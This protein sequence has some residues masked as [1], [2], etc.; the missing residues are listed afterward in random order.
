M[1]S[2]LKI[3]PSQQNILLLQQQ[4][5]LAYEMIKLDARTSIVS[6]LCRIKKRSVLQL[7]SEVH[8][9][10]ESTLPKKGLLPF[11]PFWLTKSP[12]NCL[13]A[14]IFYQIYKHI[15]DNSPLDRSHVL[16]PARIF[17][18]SFKVYERTANSDVLNINRAWSIGQQIKNSDIHT[19]FC[20]R[21]GSNYLS[22]K[23]CPQLFKLCPLC[24][25]TV[26][27]RKRKRW[28]QPKSI[29]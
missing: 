8:D 23:N 21:C 18:E 9:D 6:A 14:S 1:E 24:D 2:R 28:V 17:V 15:Y 5:N 4:L 13:Q 22:I 16:F 19:V 3:T 20:D 11:D 12:D 10:K 25:V 7:Y 26:D 29:G 27:S